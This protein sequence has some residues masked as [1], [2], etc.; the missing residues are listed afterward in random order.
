MRQLESRWIKELCHPHNKN[1]LRLFLELD[2]YRRTGLT[3]FQ[4][5]GMSVQER[6]LLRKEKE[7]LMHK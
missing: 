3:A 7:G 1:R 5:A 4:Q 6:Y 2:F